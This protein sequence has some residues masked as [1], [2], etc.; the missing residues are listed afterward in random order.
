[1]GAEEAAEAAAAE[2]EAAEVAAAEEEAAGAGAAEEGAAEAVVA[3]K[4]AAGS[5]IRFLPPNPGLPHNQAH[6]DQGEQILLLPSLLGRIL[7][8][9][10]NRPSRQ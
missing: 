3:E 4:V 2:E 1:M 5:V 6:W 9:P 8:P 10:Y 7:R